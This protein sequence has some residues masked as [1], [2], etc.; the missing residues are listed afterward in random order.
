VFN[1]LMTC[2]V[3]LALCIGATCLSVLAQDEKPAEPEKAKV[4]RPEPPEEFKKLQV[5]DL[6]DEKRIES[7]K[8]LFGTHCEICH[9]KDGTGS[10]MG[11]ALKPAAEDL[12][13]ADLQ[14]AMSDSYI[15]WRITKGGAALD[16][17]GMT[18]FEETLK[19]DQRWALVAFVRSIDAGSDE[20]E[21]K[22]KVEPLTSDEM[23]ALMDEIKGEWKALG[24]AAEAKDKDKA[25]AAADKLAE[26]AGKLPGYDG[27]VKGGDHDGEKVRDQ[28]DWK[29]FREDFKKA[30]EEYSAL[31]KAGEWDK[32]GDA[33]PNIGDGCSNC[34]DV[35]KP[36]KR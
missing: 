27:N 35:Y 18:A 6:K 8:E 31:A 5:P 30:A 23:E 3:T 20:A 16:Y 11:S 15:Y 10:M 28:A 7:G 4:E 12:T 17:V 36:K 19:E 26:L 14:A 24:K 21:E 32:A 22:P 34:H 9:G 29:K 1:K 25:S 2:M 13:N 33:Q